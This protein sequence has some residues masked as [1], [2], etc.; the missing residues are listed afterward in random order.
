MAGTGESPTYVYVAMK[1]TGESKV[2]SDFETLASHYRLKELNPEFYTDDILRQ[3]KSSI[4]GAA[5][6]I[7]PV[8]VNIGGRLESVFV[9][10]SQII[11]SFKGGRRS[12][13]TF[14]RNNTLHRNVRRH[15]VK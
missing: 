12:R 4:D 14:R 5:G 8:V 15:H 10:R 11:G 9:S 6:G 2:F 1:Q 13:R 7:V 3:T